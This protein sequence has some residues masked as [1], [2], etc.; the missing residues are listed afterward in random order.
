MNRPWI[1]LALAGLVGGTLLLAPSIA[2][3]SEAPVSDGT[4]IA[5]AEAADDRSAAKEKESELYD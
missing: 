3:G 4:A 1:P 2:R 5:L